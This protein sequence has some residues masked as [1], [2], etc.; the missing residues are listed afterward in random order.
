MDRIIDL[1]FGGFWLILLML[2][3]SFLEKVL[4]L[5]WVFLLWILILNDVFVDLGFKL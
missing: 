1:Y 3:F 2:Y 4:V 5:D